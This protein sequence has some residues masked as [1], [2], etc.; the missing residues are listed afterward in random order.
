MNQHDHQTPTDDQTSDGDFGWGGLANRFNISLRRISREHMQC[1]TVGVG[2]VLAAVGTAIL[3]SAV[4]MVLVGIR[5]FL[6]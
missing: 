4:I 6:D 5:F 1:I 2:L 3:A